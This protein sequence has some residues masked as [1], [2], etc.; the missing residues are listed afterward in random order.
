MTSN[1]SKYV[2][3]VF[4]VLIGYFGYQWWWNPARAVKRQLGE[5]AARLS[6]PANETDLARVARI[7]QLRRHFAA[8]VRVQSGTDGAALTSRD[9]LLAAISALRAPT[10]GWEVQFVDVQIQMDS[11]S[12]SRAYMTVELKGRDPR[13]GDPTVDAREATVTLAK[14][15]GAWVVTTAE[16]REIPGTPPRP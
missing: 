4:A 13:T 16:S 15:D 11:S 6:I 8:D 3:V 7:A 5:L 9:A 14:Q 1:G 2:V 10:S 12:A